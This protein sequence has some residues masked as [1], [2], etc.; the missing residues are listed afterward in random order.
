MT[1]TKRPSRYSL[2]LLLAGALAS[3]CVERVRELTASERAQVR[4]Y[5]STRAPHPQHRTR[6]KFGDD[7]ELVGYD[8]DSVDW[9]PGSKVRFT[10]YWHALDEVGEG[11]K[12][13]T[14]VCDG[15]GALRFPADDEGFTRRIYPVSR[16][17]EGEYVRD[18]Q[19]ITLP[20]GFEGPD[21]A[22]YLGVYRGDERAPIHG[23]AN[24]GDNRARIVTLDTGTPRIP[25]Q[26]LDIIRLHVA[27]VATP[28]TID[29]RL[30]EPAWISAIPSGPFVD[31]MSGAQTS[32][33]A[34]V[35][36]LWDETTLYVAF[37]VSDPFLVSP[38]TNLDD[39]LWEN[40][41]VEIMLDPGGDGLN[42][43]EL[44]ANPLG[45]VF[46]TRYDSRRVPQPFGHVD[47]Q[48]GMRTGVTV[49]S[50]VNDA[51]DDES[52]TVELALPFSAFATGATP[53]APPTA[54]QVWRGNFYV[55]DTMRAGQRAAAWSAPRIGDFHFPPRFGE[56][57]FEAA[58]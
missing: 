5:V 53:A 27:H 1:R 49:Q 51:I 35:R 25:N 17:H 20:L 23:G 28:P 22:V 16:F 29:G 7:L 2:A 12:V 46:D 44:Q 56:L 26:P 10:W 52:Y 55:M 33:G 13:F 24:D 39:H 15:T 9:H 58:P 3:S 50:G 57:A 21:A 37:E 43:F 54:G 40:D 42:Y 19:E 48:S 14:H 30:N 8:V 11:W 38:F 32:L 41:C 34:S 31:T 4:E 36:A 47:W 45:T 6:I 18:V